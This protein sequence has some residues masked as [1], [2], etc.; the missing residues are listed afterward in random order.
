MRFIPAS[1]CVNIALIRWIEY[2]LPKAKSKIGRLVDT[3]VSLL[4]SRLIPPMTQ[5]TDTS[6]LN[7]A[8]NVAANDLL[9][10][11]IMPTTMIATHG[12]NFI[13]SPRAVSA[14]Y[15]PINGEPP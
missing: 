6:T 13:M 7:N 12:I 1:K 15:D 9:V 10:T 4:P 3:N 11:R 8:I 14:E 5:M 2:A